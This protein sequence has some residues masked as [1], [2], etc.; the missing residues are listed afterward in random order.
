MCVCFLVK[1]AL[2]KITQHVPVSWSFLPQTFTQHVIIY[3]FVYIIWYLHQLKPMGRTFYAPGS[4]LLLLLDYQK[5]P[6]VILNILNN[7]L[8]VISNAILKTE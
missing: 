6:T 8:R 4:Q 3:L 2:G 7:W 5:G 1:I